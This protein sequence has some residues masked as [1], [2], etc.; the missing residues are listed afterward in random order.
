LPETFHLEQE[1]DSDDIMR[2]HDTAHVDGA[3]LECHYAH[4][5]AAA[6]PFN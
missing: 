6:I 3:M 2:D 4:M 5:R 1:S